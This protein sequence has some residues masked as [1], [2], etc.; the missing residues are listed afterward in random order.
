[1][2]TICPSCRSSIAVDDINVS[3]DLALCRSCG[4]THRFSQ[5]VEGD[6]ASG[7]DLNSLPPGVWFEQLANGFSVGAT[8][9]SWMAIFLVPFT[10]VWAGGSVGGIYGRQIAH[11]HFDAVSS[12]FGLPFLIGSCVLVSMCALYT[13][14]KITVTQDSDRLSIFCG[15][16]WLGWTRNYVWSD[17][18]T[19]REDSGLNGFNWNRQG[20]LIVLEGKRRVAF[21]S[22]WTEDR[23]YFVLNAIRPFLHNANRYVISTVATT[24]FR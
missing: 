15:V 19:I 7:P 24:K 13:A 9:R 11:R 12:L 8:T 17:F 10:C 21:G 1:M 6:S 23:R 18:R 3:T 5:I 4:R 20:R 16:G 14:G 2:S 22:M